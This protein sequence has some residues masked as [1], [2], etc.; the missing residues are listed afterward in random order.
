M[1]VCMSNKLL[2][3]WLASQRSRNLSSILNIWDRVF[4]NTKNSNIWEN[5]FIPLFILEAIAFLR[6]KSGT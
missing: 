2:S 1:A 4:C 5:N 3:L 6:V